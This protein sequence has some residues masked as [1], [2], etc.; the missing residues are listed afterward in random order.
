MEN[1]QNR[2]QLADG[3]IVPISSL[4]WWQKD[5]YGWPI[6]L[7]RNRPIANWLRIVCQNIRK[8]TG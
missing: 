2:V 4:R 8:V 7:S 1:E 5:K 6:E 3:R